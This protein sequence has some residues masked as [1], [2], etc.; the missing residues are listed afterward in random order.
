MKKKS[1][2]KQLL[3]PMMT[4]AVALPAVVLIIFSASYEQEVLKKN[5]EQSSLMAEEISIFMDG[6]YH[7]NEELADNPRVFR[8]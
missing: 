8:M 1:I 4:L 7:I 2:F 5:K 3:I 6:A